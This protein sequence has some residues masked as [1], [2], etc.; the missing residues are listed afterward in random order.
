MDLSGK[1]VLLTGAA[2][3]LGE[4]TARGFAEK[5]ATLILCSRNR[6]KLEAMAAELPNGPHQVIAGDLTAPGAVDTIVE[7]A[8]TVDILF[9]NAG[10]P[11]GFALDELPADE[12]HAVVTVN[13]EIPIQLAKAVI[14]QMKERGNGQIVLVGSMAGKFAL[15]DSTLYSSTKAGLRAFGWALRPEL[16]KHG[17]GVT[18]VTQSFVSE[19]GMFAKRNRKA[20]AGA[21][22]VKPTS[23]VAKVLKGIEH[24]KG[25]IVI[26]PPQLRLLS[27]A[28]TTMPSLFDRV[29]RRAAPQRKPAE[30]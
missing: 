22:T 24:D 5:G 1:R 2:G 29:F 8:D 30:Q 28:S 25:E 27:V 11:G 23:Y 17:I 7:Q 10:R 19:V 15:P 4:V 3:G 6:E 9:A 12:I 13:F 20:P 14:P 16:A 21:G 18:V 26:A